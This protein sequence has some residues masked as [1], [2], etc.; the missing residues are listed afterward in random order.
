MPTA[1]CKNCGHP[2][3]R[4]DCG[5]DDCGCVKYVPRPRRDPARLRTWLITASFFVRNHWI[6]ADVKVKAA[7]A[8]G[9]AMKGLREAKQ[10]ALT[11]RTR[12]TQTKI[13]IV[14]VPLRGGAR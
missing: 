3:H 1:Y 9:A 5:V 12:V 8:A 7:G 11:P 6:D 14:P 4:A 10:T 2:A 13:T